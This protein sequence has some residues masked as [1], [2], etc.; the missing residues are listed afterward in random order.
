MPSILQT[1]NS[2]AIK[3]KYL[4]VL[5]SWDKTL[6]ETPLCI[7]SPATAINSSHATCNFL[8]K[9]LFART[10]FKTD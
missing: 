10:S 7:T 8:L 4:L 6:V 9:E 3:T 5:L 1:L 2:Y